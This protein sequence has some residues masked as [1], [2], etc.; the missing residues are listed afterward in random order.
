MTVPCSRWHTI[1]VMSAHSADR[2]SPDQR[3][4]QPDREA[5]VAPAHVHVGH[6]HVHDAGCGHP[7]VP[8]ESHVDYL[9]GEH[10]HARHDAHYDEH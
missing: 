8:H 6:M 10:R 9:H 5:A 2:P 7:A 3:S 4:D 1:L